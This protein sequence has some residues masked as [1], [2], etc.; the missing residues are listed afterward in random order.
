MALAHPV[1]Y[2]L[3]S[4]EGFREV[5]PHVFLPKMVSVIAKASPKYPYLN[6][7]GL[8]CCSWERNGSIVRVI[9][10]DLSIFKVF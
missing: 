6:S 8:V 2:L 5:C 9:I 3:K 7:T 1:Y 10:F 4:Q